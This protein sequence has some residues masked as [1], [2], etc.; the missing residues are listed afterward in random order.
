MK[1]GL[2]VYQDICVSPDIKQLAQLDSLMEQYY[3]EEK[4][5]HFYAKMLG[6][7]LKTLNRVTVFHTGRTVY[8][9]LQD[10]ALRQ[11]QGLILYSKVP[12]K[13]IAYEIGFNS[14]EYFSRWFKK[15][16]GMTAR[17]FKRLNRP[18]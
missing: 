17:E 7:S 3:R 12:V 13:V 4:D 9:L 2:S 8:R 14:P 5:P 11:A 16:T 1:P 6:H 10:K 15:V 18:H